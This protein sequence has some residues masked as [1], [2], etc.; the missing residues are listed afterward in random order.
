MISKNFNKLNSFLQVINKLNLEDDIDS[1]EHSCFLLL[2]GD[3]NRGITLNGQAYSPLIDSLKDEIESHGYTCITI[4]KPWSR[5]VGDK[6]YGSPIAINKSYLKVKMKQKLFS[7]LLS[8]VEFLFYK[9]IISKTNAKVI[10]TIGASKAF[11]QAA[12]SLNVFHSE[13]LH[14]IGYTELKW[15]L[16]S[17]KNDQ[18]P[19]CILSLDSVSTRTLLPLQKK[20]VIIKQIPHPFLKKFKYNELSEVPVEWRLSNKFRQNKKEILISVQWGFSADIDELS[21]LKGILN[22]GMFYD[23]LANV[24]R[25]TSNDVFWRFRLHPVQYRNPKRYKKLLSFID[26][27]VHQHPNCDWKESTYKP[28]PALLKNCSGHITMYS[29]TSYEASY[30]GVPT[31]ALSPTLKEDGVHSSMFSDLIKNGYLQKEKATVSN[32][33]NWVQNTKQK[34]PML[35]NLSDKIDI[36]N[37]LL[38]QVK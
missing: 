23:E 35:N 27:F 22:N 4:A 32:I 26:D 30:F 37:W 38:T 25:Q 6:A 1:I 28:L 8:D 20:G 21:E 13:L 16:S 31:L 10:I 11:C 17:L 2:C 33:I 5:L 24:V 18:L 7:R 34:P 9:D 3:A 12:R 15:D 36:T 14:G 19:Q 29:M